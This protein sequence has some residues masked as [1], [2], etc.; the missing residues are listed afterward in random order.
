MLGSGVTTVDR[1][2]FFDVGHFQIVALEF[3]WICVPGALAAEVTRD[4]SYRSLLTRCRGSK[5]VNMPT[6]DRVIDKI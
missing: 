6:L 5:N 4:V 2:R 3:I 1:F